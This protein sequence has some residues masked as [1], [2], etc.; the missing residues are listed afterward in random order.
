LPAMALGVGHLGVEAGRGYQI[1]T[2]V[3]RCVLGHCSAARH[4]RVGG[5]FTMRFFTHVVLGVKSGFPEGIDGALEAKGECF[6]SLGSMK[7]PSNASGGVY[8]DHFQPELSRVGGVSR[9]T[10]RWA[11]RVCMCVRRPHVRHAQ[12]E[13]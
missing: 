9:V 8:L 10:R 1:F 4:A 7:S 12:K 13:K 2:M 11:L 6:K 5:A 3:G